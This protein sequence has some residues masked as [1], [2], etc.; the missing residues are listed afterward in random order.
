MDLMQKKSGQNG[1]GGPWLFP[2]CSLS[3]IPAL[4]EDEEFS[5]SFAE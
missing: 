5:S 3:P 1:E 4:Q 2:C